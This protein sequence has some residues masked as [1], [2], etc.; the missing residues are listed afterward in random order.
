[1]ASRRTFLQQTATTAFG[2]WALNHLPAAD[3]LKKKRKLGVQLF[4]FFPSFEQDV[5]GNLKKIA[6]TGI[7]DIESAYSL[8]GGF[9]GMGA[10]EFRKMVEDLGMK[11]R[12]QHVL[13]A[14][15]KPNP[16]FDVS[17]MP[18]F[19][20]LK[21]ESQQIVDSMA[22][23]GVKYLVCANYPHDTLDEWKEGLAVLQ[24]TGEQAKKAGMVLAYHNHASEFKALDGV[25]PYD[26]MCSQVSGDVLQLE[27][28]LAWASQ[29]G[30]DPVTLFHKYPGRF[31]LWHVKDF[32]EGYKNLKPVGEGIIDFKRI[33]AA[34]KVAGTK[35]FFIEHDMPADAF[36]SIKSSVTYLRNM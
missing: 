36:A 22:E 33:F 31:P 13:G 5:P 25:I 26:L 27:L 2:A 18:K 10:K 3:L 9:Y 24:K 15:L 32:D 14:P 28:D 17:K 8:K 21:N 12:S 4:T 1:M 20:T 11:W 30:I 6:D 16:Q 34:A 7:V 19:N 29:A 35:H 23:S